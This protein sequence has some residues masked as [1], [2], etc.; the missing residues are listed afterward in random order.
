[1]THYNQNPEFTPDVVYSIGLDKHLMTYMH[2][3]NIIEYFYF[4]KNSLYSAY[5]SLLPPL[6]DSFYSMPVGLVTAGVIVCVSISLNI[7]KTP[8]VHWLPTRNTVFFPHSFPSPARNLYQCCN[9]NNVASSQQIKPLF[10]K[11]D[12]MNI[13]AGYP[14]TYWQLLFPPPPVL[15]H[16]GVFLK[17]LLIFFVSTSKVCCGGGGEAWKRMRLPLISLASRCLP[18]SPVH[19][20]VWQYHS[21]NPTVECLAMSYPN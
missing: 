13:S 18:L 19:C 5:S 11:G 1:M 3:Y 9:D 15:H 4:P 10:S 17:I 7:R 12:G 20:S 2:Y 6:K 16:E 21:W 14:N 8:Y